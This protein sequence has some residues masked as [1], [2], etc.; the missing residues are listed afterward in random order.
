MS[1]ELP[2]LTSEFFYNSGVVKNYK[3]DFIGAKKDFDLALNLAIKSPEPDL[4]ARFLLSI[5]NNNYNLG[6]V[7][8]AIS[9][10][11]KLEE[12][13]HIVKKNYLKGAMYLFWSKILLEEDL[14]DESLEK[15]NKAITQLKEKRSVGI[16]MDMLFLERDKFIKLGDYEKSLVYFNLSTD[17]TDSIQFR[18][19]TKMI[20]S[21]INEVNDSSIDIY[22]DRAN[23]KV[24]EKTLGTIDF[25]ASFCFTRNIVFIGQEYRRIL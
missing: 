22:L 13:L 2:S 12:L 20:E 6:H 15:I 14:C 7:S 3:S 1:V 11:N 18:R 8:E 9:Q 17:F 23:R 19:L 4:Q 10:L 21:E 16:Y 25:K 24:V 5:A